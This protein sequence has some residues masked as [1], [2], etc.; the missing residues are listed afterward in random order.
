M[1]KK[2]IRRIKSRNYDAFL[3]KKLKNPNVAAE[4]LSTAIQ[5]GSTEVFLSA[6]KNVAE[7]HGGIGILSSITNL[8]RQSMYKMFSEKGNPT[9]SSLVSVLSAVGIDLSFEPQERKI[10]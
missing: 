7:A 3:R 6:L 2:R 1:A 8:N 10:A 4:Y 9:L 5:D